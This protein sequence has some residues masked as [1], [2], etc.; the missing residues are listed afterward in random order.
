MDLVICVVLCCFFVVYVIIVDVF[1]V[2]FL[3]VGGLI[4]IDGDLIKVCGLLWVMIC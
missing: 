2:I 1:I 3:W 4:V